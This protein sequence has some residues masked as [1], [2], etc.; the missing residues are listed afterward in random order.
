[1]LNES[2]FVSDVIVSKQVKL[3][4]GSEHKLFF[5][6]IPAVEFR[7][8]YI[9]EQSSDDEVKANSMAKLI[10]ASLCNEDGTPA[11]TLKQALRLK[12][13]AM[14]GIVSA[15]MEVNGFGNEAKNV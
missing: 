15:I 2:L 11:I 8:F 1:M 9:A 10:T 4:D 6:E 5:K 12:G 3:S 13:S 14:N 7:K